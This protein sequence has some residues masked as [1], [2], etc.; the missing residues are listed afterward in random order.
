MPE[1]SRPLVRCD[2]GS[3]RS[4]ARPWRAALCLALAAL[5]LSLAVSCSRPL[6]PVR[7]EGSLQSAYPPKPPPKPRLAAAPAFAPAGAVTVAPGDTVYGIARRFGVPIRTII[8]ANHL[9]PPYILRVGQRLALAEPRYHVVKR[10][11]TL[12]A[13]SRLYEV[14]LTSLARLNRIGPPYALPLGERL[15][16]P[17]TVAGAR[18]M[19]RTGS[20]QPRAAPAPAAAPAAA[21]GPAVIASNKVPLPPPRAG[22]NFAWPVNGKLIST[23]GAKGGGLHNDGVNIAAPRGTPVRAAENGVVAY[24]G[25]ELKG[26]GNLLL[27][28]HQGGW[29]TAY[30]HNDVLQ[31]RRGDTVKRGQVIARLGSTGHVSVPQLHFEIRKG[32]KAVDPLRYLGR[33][34]SRESAP[35]TRPGALSRAAAPAAP[36]ALG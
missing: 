15:L 4:L 23:F 11:E 20:A 7:L 31:V 2:A 12:Y 1:F 27:V 36:P 25:N 6:A 18:R 21:P 35:M 28:R 14:D 24:A 34:T 3:G 8:E 5:T 10:G 9:S 32:A 29:T 22:K 16:L 13:I 26:F 19:A 30:A 17:G 33:R